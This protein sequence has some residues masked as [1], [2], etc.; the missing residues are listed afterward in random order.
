[1]KK[2]YFYGGLSLLLLVV[3][4]IQ[5]Y[6]VWNRPVV[7]VIMTTHNR[8]ES[9]LIRALD[10]LL[11][12]TY[13]DFEVIVVND[14]SSDTT[15]EVL[16]KYHQKDSRI[17]PLNLAQNVGV[18]RARALGMAQSRGRYIAILDDDDMA[19]P[20]W[21]ERSVAYLDTY[22]SITVVYPLRRLFAS[23]PNH[24]WNEAAYP[25]SGMWKNNTVGN[26]GCVYRKEFQLQHH[27][28]Y[29]LSYPRAEDYGFWVDFLKAGATFFCIPE[30][31]VRIHHHPQDYDESYR[32]EQQKSLY[33]IRSG[34]LAFKHALTPRT[35]EECLRDN[36]LAEW[37]LKTGMLPSH[38]VECQP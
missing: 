27:I 10:S 34:F 21:L 17:K 5:L 35:R 37:N 29:N 8:A 12:Q 9:G 26:V 18:I 16:S 22:P 4:I 13:T 7:S 38:E 11:A 3:W 28:R 1:M 6:V 24:V 14:A 30:R 36:P 15:A 31:L 32:Q 2:A 33:R 25:I 20:L 19:E 23:D